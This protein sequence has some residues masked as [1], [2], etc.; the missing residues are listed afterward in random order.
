MGK[1][2]ILFIAAIFTVGLLVANAAMGLKE[3]VIARN[4]EINQTIAEV[5]K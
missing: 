4:I 5:S 2:T 1:L 3:K